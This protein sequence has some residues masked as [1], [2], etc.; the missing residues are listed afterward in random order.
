MMENNTAVQQPP[1]K[2]DNRTHPLRQGHGKQDRL[3]LVQHKREAFW[4]Y[5][6]LS[7]VYDQFV[8]PWH[9]TKN[10]RA[11]A[12]GMA[13]L[14]SDDLK[15]LDVG[16]G[17]GFCTEGI[18]EQGVAPASITL[19]DQSPHQMAKAKA[20]PH[21]QGVTFCE[22]DAEDLP[23]ETD[24]FDR[25]VSAGS[26][27]Y[28]PEPQRGINEAY[29][30]IRP[31]GIATIIGPEKATN[32]FSRYLSD[33]WMLFPSEE[34]YEAWFRAAGFSDITI[35]RICPEHF[36]GIRQHGL[37]M[38]LVV[39]GRKEKAGLPA[40]R[41]A[42]KLETSGDNNLTFSQRCLVPLRLCA[43]S[44]GGSY[45]FLLGFLIP[46]LAKLSGKRSS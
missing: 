14:G 8:N 25:Y 32:Q 16:G 6:F 33:L 9:W 27:E 13:R 15:V 2:T 24:E 21:L 34:E 44:V 11:E 23:F 46:V 37:I 4:F 43:G 41:L 19:L 5:R 39:S 36:G 10:M 26:I 12:L 7:I 31:G 18:I 35:E 17:T 28:W 29:R 20:K 40:L 30:V 3:G 22:G 42:T 1:K 45:Y 38:G